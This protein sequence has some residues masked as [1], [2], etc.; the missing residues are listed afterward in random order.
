MGAAVALATVNWRPHVETRR[1]PPIARP[2]HIHQHRHL[3]R[4]PTMPRAAP[5]AAARSPSPARA[6][7]ART[8]RGGGAV[9]GPAVT[10]PASQPVEPAPAPAPAPVRSSSRISSAARPPALEPAQQSAAETVAAPE[11]V[12]AAPPAPAAVAATKAPPRIIELFLTACVTAMIA[13]VAANR[14]L[15]PGDINQTALGLLGVAPLL[16]TLAVALVRLQ[17]SG[18]PVR[19]EISTSA[20]LLV[21]LGLMAASKTAEVTLGTAFARR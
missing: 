4:T 1:R 13:F 16:L 20:A 11:A 12:E 17:H 5:G 14:W 6:R 10:E 7:G 18:G 15:G 9:D 19:S 21:S 3:R 8:K 2:L